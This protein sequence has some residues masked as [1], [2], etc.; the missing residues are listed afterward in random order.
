MTT[1]Q[2]HNDDYRLPATGYWANAWKLS[3]LLGIIGLIGS[4]ITFATDPARYGYAYLF[5]WSVALTIAL[6][7]MFL[8]LVIHVTQGHWGI[9]TRRLAEVIMLGIIAVAV[10]AVPLFSGIASGKFT[11]YDEWMHLPSHAE[12]AAHEHAAE[13]WTL[14][15]S[16]AHAQTLGEADIDY[17]HPEES[18]QAEQKHHETL[19]FKSGYLNQTGWLVRSVIYLAI[20]ILIAI[21]FFRWSTRQDETGDPSLTVRMRSWSYI[22][23]I[24]FSLALTWAAFDWLMALEPAWFSTIFGVIV[25]AASA[26]AIFA[27]ITLIGL[28]LVEHGH[29]T[30]AI[31]IEH[32]HDH[33]KLMFGFICFWTYV[34]FAQW[35]LIWYAG[36]PEESTWYQHRWTGGWQI[37]SYALIFGHFVLPFILLMSRNQKRQLGWLKAMCI[38]VLVMHVIDMYWFVL[39]TYGSTPRLAPNLADVSALLLVGGLFFSFV[40]YVLKRVNLVAVEDPRL[41]RSIHLHQSY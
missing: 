1:A 31:T 32:F 38:F 34:Q 10:L 23:M 19:Q 39:P 22:S 37:V 5:A 21:A 25:F 13:G 18:P 26:V 33:A 17:G 12:G 24:A 2:Q 9:T 7:G 6:G 40:F 15:A 30:K 20:W 8:V 14:G 36:I 35:L 29:A 3:G 11:M 4:G 41:A 28:S 16:V 27:V